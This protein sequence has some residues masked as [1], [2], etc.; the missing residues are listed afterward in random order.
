MRRVT[1]AQKL[2]DTPQTFLIS[3]QKLILITVNKFEVPFQLNK[4]KTFKKKVQMNFDHIWEKLSKTDRYKFQWLRRVWLSGEKMDW[5][6]DWLLSSTYFIRQNLCFIHEGDCFIRVSK[7]EETDE[8]TRQRPSA[9]IVLECLETL[10][11]H[12]ARVY[13]M[14]SPKGL[15]Y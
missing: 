14:A 9:F 12:E 8:R 13:R 10:M 2:V 11:K 3:L 1:S 4:L 7:H 6:D 5:Y 15:I